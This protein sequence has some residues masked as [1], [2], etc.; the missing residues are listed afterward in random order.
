MVSPPWS[1]SV[2]ESADDPFTISYSPRK[3]ARPGSRPYDAGTTTTMAGAP[4]RR[5]SS[6]PAHPRTMAA[7]AVASC[8][9]ADV[10]SVKARHLELPE[11][12]VEPVPRPRRI[13]D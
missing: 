4:I 12:A 10:A 8:H 6:R 1:E 7:M 9:M 13:P 11:T 5:A 3:M 2:P